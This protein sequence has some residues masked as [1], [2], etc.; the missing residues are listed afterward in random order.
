MNFL[1]WQKLKITSIW[2]TEELS[3]VSFDPYPT[4]NEESIISNVA[5]AGEWAVHREDLDMSH[6]IEMTKLQLWTLKPA[7]DNSV[8]SYH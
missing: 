3:T 6:L 1:L 2:D 4:V 8:M 5:D 7:H